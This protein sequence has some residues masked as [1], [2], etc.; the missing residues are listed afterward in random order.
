MLERLDK[1]EPKTK[2]FRLW[3]KVYAKSSLREGFYAVYRNGG[4]PGVDHQTVEQFDREFLQELEKLEEELRSG[5]YQPA[6]ARRQWIPKPGSAEKRP[7]GIPTVRDRTV[8][9]ALKMVVEPIFERQFAEQSYGFR[10]GRGCQD[11]VKRVEE[12]LKEG[13]CVIVDADLKS[14]FD[15]IPHERLMSRIQEQIEDGKVLGLIRLFLKAGVL[16]EMK[17]WKPTESGTPQG[18]VISPLLS[19]IYLHELDETMQRRGWQMVRYADDF[20]VMCHNAQEAQEVMDYL[21]EWT[22]AAGLTLHPTKTRV[23]DYGRGESFQFL[24]WHFERGMKWPREKSIDK[25]RETVREKTRRTRGEAMGDIVA[26]LNSTLKGWHG[27]FRESVKNVLERQDQ[28]IRRRLRAM[29]RKREKRPG[30]GRTTADHTKWRNAWFA[31]Q[32]LFSLRHGSCE[33]H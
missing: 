7:L 3:D 27:Y 21:R 10:P 16:E 31:E 17:D 29:L 9:A 8:Q 2:W 22:E 4:A 12:L 5:M 1:N 11:A 32:G 15:T 24:G 6:P 28:F 30:S 19:N 20:V 26:D 23:I 33:Y 25:L 13:R 18:G 14:Y